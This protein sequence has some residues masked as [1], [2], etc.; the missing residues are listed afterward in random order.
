MDSH[1]GQSTG[2]STAIVNAL[3]PVASH[4]KPRSKRERGTAESKE[5]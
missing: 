2:S 4:R 5:L 3:S 1:L